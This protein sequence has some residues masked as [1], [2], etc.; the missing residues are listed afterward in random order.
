MAA[1]ETVGTLQLLI[2]AELRFQTRCMISNSLEPISSRFK[3]EL[4]IWP[5]S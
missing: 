2:T 4:K 1:V 5:V 3:V